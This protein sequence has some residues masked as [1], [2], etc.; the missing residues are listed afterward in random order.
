MTKQLE[1]LL[2]EKH[3]SYQVKLPTLGKDWNQALELTAFNEQQRQQ[4]EQ[5]NELTRLEATHPCQHIVIT[6]TPLEALYLKQ[7]RL[8]QI[9]DLQEQIEHARDAEKPLLEE[10]LLDKKHAYNSSMYVSLPK[11]IDEKSHHQLETSL[12]T[13]NSKASRLL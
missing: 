1:A 3:C 11:E 6:Q 12:R 7:E 4:E 10:Q 9:K 2:Q 13:L 8:D 5:K